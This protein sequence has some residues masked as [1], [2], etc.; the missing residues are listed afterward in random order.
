MWQQDPTGQRFQWKPDLGS[1]GGNWSSVGVN[2]ASEEAS[3]HAADLREQ[4]NAH[5]LQRSEANEDQT[6]NRRYMI[7]DQ[8]R[9]SAAMKQAFSEMSSGGGGDLPPISR[10]PVGPEGEDVASAL[11]FGRAKDQ[12]GQATRGLLKSVRHNMASRGIGG[13]GIEG[14]A[15]MDVLAGGADRVANA[16]LAEAIARVQ[17]AQSV[18]DRNYAGNI[19]QRGQDIG[20]RQAA[21]DRA[22]TR[23]R[24]YIEMITRTYGGAY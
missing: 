15:S 3:Q 4:A 24:Q 16:G 14:A 21:A 1:G 22:E 17:R 11:A 6:L 18:N 9:R 19:A 8:A 12:A 10:V 23:R 13:S 20:E 2:R 5:N 7:E